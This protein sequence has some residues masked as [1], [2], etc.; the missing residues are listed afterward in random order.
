MPQKERSD[1]TDKNTLVRAEN[2]IGHLSSDRLLCETKP[3]TLAI[4]PVITFC[5]IIV[6][7]PLRKV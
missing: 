1:E 6:C 3:T 4:F 5:T 2:S 7:P